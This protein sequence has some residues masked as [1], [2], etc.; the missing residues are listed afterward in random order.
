MRG[1]LKSIS[2]DEIRLRVFKHF[3]IPLETKESPHE[4]LRKAQYS[5]MGQKDITDKMDYNFR[6]HE[7]IMTKI[8]SGELMPGMDPLVD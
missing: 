7:E 6:A 5:F 4:I 8:L 3:H 2:L 1:V